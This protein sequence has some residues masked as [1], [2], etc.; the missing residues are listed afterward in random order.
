MCFLATGDFH[1]DRNL[2]DRFNR[3]HWPDVTSLISWNV[4]NVIKYT[5]FG[6]GCASWRPVSVIMIG[7]KVF[8]A[9]NDRF[10]SKLTCPPTVLEIL[11]QLP[12]AFLR[13]T[14][15]KNFE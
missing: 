13:A 3:I 5:L 14:F 7:I 2:M 4:F 1:L 9:L 12:E 8:R 6:K 15:H 11:Q 10:P